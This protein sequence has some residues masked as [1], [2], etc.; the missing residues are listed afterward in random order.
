MA[1]GIARQ[2][3]RAGKFLFKLVDAILQVVI[4]REIDPRSPRADFSPDEMKSPAKHQ[5][6]PPLVM[7]ISPLTHAELSEARNTAT[8]A[9]SLG[10]PVRPS[11]VRSRIPFSKSE[12][13]MPALR[14]PSVSTTPGLMELTRIFLVPNSLDNTPVMASSEALVAV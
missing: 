9:I 10:C 3:F 1:R 5:R 11:G 6:N 4:E 12:P 14:V 7:M 8:A 13:T 2:P